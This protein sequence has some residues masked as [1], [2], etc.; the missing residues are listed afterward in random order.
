MAIGIKKDAGEPKKD[1]EEE[2]LDHDPALFSGKKIGI[3][4]GAVVVVIVLLAVVIPKLTASDTPTTQQQQ[5]ASTSS[6]TTSEGGTTGDGSTTG[7]GG[8][9]DDSL[10]QFGDSG[11]QTN[12]YT[13]GDVDYDQSDKNKTT[14]KVYDQGEY[15]KD[16][17]GKDISAVYSVKSREY[18]KAHV[19]YTA[20]RAII[21]EGMEMYWIDVKYKKKKYRVQVPFYYFK[22]F[23]DSGICRVEIEVLTLE[24]GGQVISYMQVVP[25]DDDS[26]SSEE[27]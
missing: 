8:T 3:A 24:N 23:D 6:G 27:Y 7:E 20:K 16:L 25:E 14:A 5:Q 26:D 10:N 9:G 11:E 22:D 19:S 13:E 21:D 15:L 4:I 12:K 17:T 1:T 2:V 18:V